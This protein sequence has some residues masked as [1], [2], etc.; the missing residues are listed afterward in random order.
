[1]RHCAPRRRREGSRESA[2]PRL[3]KTR[4]AASLPTTPSTGW[5]RTEVVAQWTTAVVDM[6]SYTM[7]RMR[8]WVLAVL[9]LWIGAARAEELTSP[10]EVVGLTE[11]VVALR[12]REYLA[13]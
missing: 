1:M 12:P 9:G 2:P 7:C 4:R 3:A 5:S 8:W 10:T 11:V 13:L 6:G